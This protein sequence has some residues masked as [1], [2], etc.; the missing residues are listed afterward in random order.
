ME[1]GIL[2][3]G[4]KM[5][6]N[7]L[8]V[9][10]KFLLVVDADPSVSGVRAELG[11]LAILSTNGIIYVKNGALDTDWAI[12]V[13]GLS[14]T[15]QSSI[16]YST[17]TFFA[18]AANAPADAIS[19]I[20][21]MPGQTHYLATD[22]NNGTVGDGTPSPLG[23]LA[24]SYTGTDAG[25]TPGADLTLLAGNNHQTGWSFGSQAGGNLNLYAGEA[26]G[27][28]DGGQ[29]SINGGNAIHAGNG[30]GGPVLINGGTPSGTGVIGP[31]TLTSSLIQLNAPVMI[32]PQGTSDPSG[33]SAGW[34]YYNSSTETLRLHN[35]TVWEDIV[36][37]ANIHLS[38]LASTAVNAPLNDS[39]GLP[40]LDLTN[41][42][43]TDSTNNFSIS[44]E[45]R[46]LFDGAALESVDYANRL[47]TYAS[48]QAS[49][50]WANSNLFDTGNFTALN[51]QN[52]T[53][54]ANDGSQVAIWNTPGLLDVPVDARIQG[55]ESIGAAASP[56]VSTILYPSTTFSTILMMEEEM[57]SVSVNQI[58][59]LTNYLSY[60]PVSD[61]TAVGVYH[62]DS[63]L[64]IPA[65]NSQTLG[66]INGAYISANHYGSGNAIEIVANSGLAGNQG[67]GLVGN[68][69]GVYADAAIAGTGNVTTARAL[70][71]RVLNTGG[72][73]VIG[74]GYGVYIDTVSATAS[75]G[76]FQSDAANQ[77]RFNGNVGIGLDPASALDIK[78]ELRLEGATSGYSGFQ[79]AGTTTSV[80][81]TLP[82]AD[83][84]A[85]YALTTD[86]SGVLSWAAASAS[87]AGSSGDVQF[88][89]S[90]SFGADTGFFSWD[91]TNKRLGLGNSSPG[92]PLHVS[93]SSATTVAGAVV[94]E[95]NN[96][97]VVGAVFM[98]RKSR[99]S[100]GSPSAI[101]S[102][103]SIVAL[104]G[105]GYGTSQYQATTINDGA[106]VLSS[107]QAFTNANHGT[108]W[109]IRTVPN[110]SVTPRI[111]AKFQQD[112]GFAIANSAGT[113]FATL[114][115][116]G[117]TDP[118]FR[119]PTTQGTS[120]QSL[121]TDGATP[122]NLSF[123]N[124]LKDTSSATSVD[125]QNRLLSDASAV[126]SID[127]QNRTVNDS[128]S[129]TSIDYENRLL[130]D[131]VA[132]GSVDWNNR[133]L[134]ANDGTTQNFQWAAPGIV[135]FNSAV[136]TSPAGGSGTIPATSLT[137]NVT[138]ARVDASSM[139]IVMLTSAD[140]SARIN[141]VVPN[142]GNFDINL[143]AVAAANT[144]FSYVIVQA[145]A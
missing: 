65:S 83:G 119:L 145:P 34:F 62:L 101:S 18:D 7:N 47:L 46:Q 112:A 105:Q 70:H 131:N 42:I 63:E 69:V 40:S 127:Y 48:A 81:Y 37:G 11:S 57:T 20:S 126:T 109:S 45:V 36:S 52:R 122:A 118:S 104:A 140:A 49:I 22:D 54:N 139:V 129:N 120:G 90:G 86:G 29:V 14:G 31:I 76:I 88:N 93:E 85:G 75:Y 137:F 141:N 115:Y 66:Y 136:I 82:D 97:S 138:D 95:N 125:Y 16:A 1:L 61:S 4:R 87:P 116:N 92:F 25:M 78:G 24:G 99:G 59:G 98:G 33:A 110:N 6:I 143:G 55:H 123:T 100:F 77:N 38:N 23:I 142:S 106:I 134:I 9:F 73:G 135:G 21:G 114:F 13:S 103:D 15:W 102:G 53:L 121:V 108:Q 117:S 17:N 113:H 74:T 51:Y 68:L 50:D 80:T 10:G 5:V 144:N 94:N 41:R 111:V 64:S 32:L 89:D 96:T 72:G 67:S 132:L 56:N 43:L 2:W 30:N 35:N 26:A 79:A 19:F 27:S 12:Q 107:T 128:S 84:T 8:K 124:Q 91:K 130:I 39:G 71:A 133:T 44:Y 58:S 3:I 60:N 28:G